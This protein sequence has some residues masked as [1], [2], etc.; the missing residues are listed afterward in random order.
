[1]ALTRKLKAR[2]LAQGGYEL[3]LPEIWVTFN[4]QGGI[5]VIVE[6]QETVSHQLV[7][8]AMVLANWL[9]ARFLAERGLPAIYRAQPEPREPIDTREP[10]DL[11]KLWLD[12]KKLSRVVMDFTPQ[13]HWGLG[14]PEYTFAT[15]PIRRYLDLVI[16]R[17]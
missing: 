16:H 14:L 3:K 8:E 5:H 10:K 9:A 7:S 11:L 1:V 17:P 13:P 6:D 4:H 15:S 2:R 12:R